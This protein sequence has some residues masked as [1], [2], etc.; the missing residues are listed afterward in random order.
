MLLGKLLKMDHKHFPS[1]FWLPT[2]VEW[3][4]SLAE[5]MQDRDP[6]ITLHCCNFHGHENNKSSDSLMIQ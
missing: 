2:S 4:S 5:K 6:N 1:C 3:H